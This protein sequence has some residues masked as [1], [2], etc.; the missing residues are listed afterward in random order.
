MGEPTD[1]GGDDITSYYIEW[2]TAASFNSLSS[3]P[4]KGTATVSS[5]EHNSYTITTLTENTVYYVRVS[6]INDMGTGTSQTTSPA[7]NFPTK[8]VPGKPHTVSVYSGTT[9]GEIDVQWQ[10]PR[11]PHH[12]IPCSG[13]TRDPDDCS[14]AVG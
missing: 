4:N 12:G 1:N 13:T 11:V 7:S 5:A 6:A 9:S 3:A 8:Q 2:D 14:A 10:Y